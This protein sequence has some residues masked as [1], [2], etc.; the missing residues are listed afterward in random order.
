MNYPIHNVIVTK[1][2]YTNAIAIQLENRIDGPI[3]TATVNIPDT[4]TSVD[5]IIV[6][7]NNCGNEIID[8]LYDNKFI[9]SKTPTRWAHSGYCSYPIFKV[10]MAVIHRN[11]Y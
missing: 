3:A 10:N 9:I 5:E 11:M 7:T 2:R 8:W 4:P 1:Y 6:D